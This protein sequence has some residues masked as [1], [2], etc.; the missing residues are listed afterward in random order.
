MRRRSKSALSSWWT[1]STASYRPCSERNLGDLEGDAVKHLMDFA[2]GL[3][4]S[5]A[6]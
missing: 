4:F 2:L 1:V 5:G 6:S 3:G